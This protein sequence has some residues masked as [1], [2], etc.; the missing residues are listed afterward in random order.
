MKISKVFTQQPETIENQNIF[1]IKSVTTVHPK[2]S[3]KL[4]NNLCRVLKIYD[5]SGF[6]KSELLK[7]KLCHFSISV[8]ET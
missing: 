6:Q 2:S 7:R 3:H 4:F 5:I 1:D 8:E